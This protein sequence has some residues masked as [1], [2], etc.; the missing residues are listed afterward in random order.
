MVARD[1]IAAAF[2]PGPEPR[3]RSWLKHILRKPEPNK[4]RQALVNRLGSLS[5]KPIRQGDVSEILIEFGVHGA[6]A[7]A[8]LVGLF[9]EAYSH[10]LSD[11]EISE[12]EQI[13]LEHLR[14]VFGITEDELRELDARLVHPR[15]D[16]VVDEVL[17]DDK[18]STEERDRLESLRRRLRLEPNTA[19]RILEQ[20]SQERIGVALGR[21]TADERLSP[22]ELADLNSLASHLGTVG[23]FDAGT[24]A[25]LDHMKL[26]W[27]IENGQLPVIQL[28]I[29]L[30]R[31]EVGHARIGAIWNE[32]RPRRVHAN[33]SGPVASIRICK[34][35]RYR[36]GSVSMEPIAR[37]ELTEI[38]R[39]TLYLTSER[40]ILD[41]SKRNITLRLSSLIGFTPYSDGVILERATGRSP[42]LVLV[43]EDIELFHA[44]LSAALDA[45]G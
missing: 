2:P 25:S 45:A 33:Y 3:P 23:A 43:G 36:I 8:M 1:P 9:S 35:L 16:A 15:F 24:R 29:N 18:I 22:T 39:G 19:A 17:A 30:Q 20:R 5:S 11:N 31:K 26:L 32:E 34:G 13:Y 10:C 27:Q 28:P 37:E 4:A 6:G 14:R 38:D 44:M 40:L 21:A 12:V 42:H 41:G 7:R